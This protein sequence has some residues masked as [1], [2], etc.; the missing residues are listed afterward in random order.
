MPKRVKKQTQRRRGRKRRMTK[1]RTGGANGEPN[2][3]ANP[4]MNQ[5]S[6]EN[7][8]A[9]HIDAMMEYLP[10]MHAANGMEGISLNTV[11]PAAYFNLWG[12]IILGVLADRW[13]GPEGGH[14]MAWSEFPQEWSAPRESYRFTEEEASGMFHVVANYIYRIYR[15]AD[16]DSEATH[17]LVQMDYD[18][19]YRTD[20]E[21]V[22]DRALL[23]ASE[24]P[25]EH[26]LSQIIGR[27]MEDYS[28]E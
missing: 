15:R 28:S 27:Y 6:L 3:P 5:P 2:A 11:S 20:F 22:L 18:D 13:E 4:P 24:H 1:R 12:S 19:E 26:D 8:L 14:R 21:N 10:P 16:P 23:E 25:G 7:E 17:V 9:D